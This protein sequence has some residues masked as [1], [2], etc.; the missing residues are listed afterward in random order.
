MSA[1]RN[2][3]YVALAVLLLVGIVFASSFGLLLSDFESKYAA[4]QVN[5]E[6]DTQQVAAASNR[7]VDLN[8]RVAQNPP[9]VKQSIEIAVSNGTYTGTGHPGELFFIAD[10]NYTYAVYRDS[11]YRWNSTTDE[12]SSRV[13]IRLRSVSA[14][15]VS[16]TLAT[17]YRNASSG[18]KQVIRQGNASPGM[19]LRTGLFER[20]N[21]YYTVT[22]TNEASV[23]ASIIFAP[24]TLVL[25]T[26]GRAYAM[27]AAGLLILLRM[28]NRDLH[29]VTLRSSLVLAAAVVPVI[30][31]LT[32]LTESGSI[33]LRY[34][35]QPA[36]GFCVALGVFAGF[37]VRCKT[38]KML[39][40]TTGLI[41]ITAVIGSAILAGP[42]AAIGAL[43]GLFIAWVASLPL[44]PYGY[45]FSGD[46]ST[47]TSLSE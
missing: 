38:K 34:V 27:V 4:Q 31:I 14:T 13:T 8:E 9:G 45:Y 5:P 33:G 44:V 35:V 11:Y 17:P 6:T 32:T 3:R 19:T 29:P 25:Q 24:I 18:I 12:N 47:G 40:A 15:R 23:F 42:F 16:D 10:E 37:T 30:W 46:E 43:F 22:V 1:S 20:N 26:V 39:A 28:K 2:R 7:V 36:A 41:V 21:T